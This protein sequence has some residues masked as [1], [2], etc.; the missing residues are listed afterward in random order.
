MSVQTYDG[1][2]GRAV[3][4]FPQG[5]SFLP[6][7]RDF[8]SDMKQ[9]NCKFGNKCALLHVLP[10]GK[11]LNSPNNNL[12]IGSRINPMAHQ[13]QGQNS[14]LG[15]S[16]STG[17]Y[18][19]PAFNHQIPIFQTQPYDIP[20]SPQ[21]DQQQYAK[22]PPIGLTALDVPMP[23][24]FDSQGVSYMARHG[25][26]A[27]SMPGALLGPQSPPA[28]LP[29]PITAKPSY[30]NN[31]QND[32]GSSPDMFLDASNA[33]QMHSQRVP[34]N[35]RMAASLPRHG[36]DFDPSWEQG[37]ET[38]FGGEDLLPSDLSNLMTPAE[39]SRRLSGKLEN[40][41]GV[42]N[43]LNGHSTPSEISSMKVGSPPFGQSPS[44]FSQYFKEQADAGSP[45]FQ[46]IGSPRALPALHPGSSPAL[47]ARQNIDS[48][49]LS[50]S[51]WTSTVSNLSIQLQRTRLNEN[52]SARQGGYGRVVSNPRTAFERVASGNSVSNTIEEDIPEGVF[53]LEGLEEEDGTT[54][55][56]PSTSATTNKP[57]ANIWGNA[58]LQQQ[59]RIVPAVPFFEKKPVAAKPAGK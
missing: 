28:S 58:G 35:R 54:S 44:R 1:Q 34:N 10:N 51:P 57:P 12:S 30:R 8:L 59:R 5:E 18:T 48:L 49:S 27:A 41:M 9:G 38:I 23:A 4:V 29:K 42:R 43:S 20:Q 52:S 25:P 16:L 36:Y 17:I 22:S 21:P 37:E 26:V 6:G 32:F 56:K 46:P 55:T 45:E 3:Q 50:G 14:V 7:L 11:Q 33:R 2:D 31:D 24:S 53:S 13:N 40:P 47:L 39:R 15:N 19:E